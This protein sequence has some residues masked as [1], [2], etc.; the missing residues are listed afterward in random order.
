MDSV[1]SD[2]KSSMS[3]SVISILWNVRCFYARPLALC[4]QISLWLFCLTL[5]VILIEIPATPVYGS[6]IHEYLTEEFV[7]NRS[8]LLKN[9]QCWLMLYRMIGDDER[10]HQHAHALGRIWTRKLQ[11]LCTENREENAIGKQVTVTYFVNE[12]YL[13][14]CGLVRGVA[15]RSLTWNYMLCSYFHLLN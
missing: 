14:D 5:R 13:S 10:K 2:V 15:K 7:C 12:I 11:V 1:C 3:I 6:Q 9:G 8:Q 4:R